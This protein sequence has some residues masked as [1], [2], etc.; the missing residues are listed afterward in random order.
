[1]TDEWQR[2]VEARYDEVMQYI[3]VLLALGELD[4]IRIDVLIDEAFAR[5]G[6]PVVNLQTRLDLIRR[7]YPDAQLPPEALRRIQDT[8][9]RETTMLQERVRLRVDEARLSGASEQEAR[10]AAAREIEAQLPRL[11]Q[12]GVDAQTMTDRV[13]LEGMG[14]PFY[15]YEGPADS[16]NRK[17]CADIVR[18]RAVFTPKGVEA[19]NAH[20][21]LHSYVPPNVA[22]LCG[23]YNCR[24]LWMPMM[25]VPE[26]WEVEGDA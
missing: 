17:F 16:K 2:E 22:V 5:A 12:R 1:M 9:R 10:D 15:L 6:A 14:A 21:L 11:T 7:Q 19:L 20:P 4:T 23:G 24:H 8:I 26:G 18:R 13:I 3:V 25:D